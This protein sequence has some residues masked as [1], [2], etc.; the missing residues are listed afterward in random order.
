MSKVKIIA[1]TKSGRYEAVALESLV[2]KTVE[3]IGNTTVEGANGPEPC[4]NLYFSDKTYH[5][6][7]L[8][9]DNWEE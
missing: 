1:G 8:P 4:I 5:G 2:G 3:A 9:S 6:F 7:V